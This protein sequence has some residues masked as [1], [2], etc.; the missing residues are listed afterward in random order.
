MVYCKMFYN[1]DVLELLIDYA[2]P[3]DLYEKHKIQLL[4]DHATH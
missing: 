2:M 3:W 1:D 4:L